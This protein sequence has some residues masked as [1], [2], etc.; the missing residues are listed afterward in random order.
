ME[1]VW[2]LLENLISPGILVAARRTGVAVK[3]NIQARGRQVAVCVYM[4]VCVCVCVC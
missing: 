1:V 2:W 4:C 3:W